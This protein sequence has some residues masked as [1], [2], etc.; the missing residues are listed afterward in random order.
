MHR[1]HKNNNE[2]TSLSQIIPNKLAKA[3]YEHKQRKGFL[4]DSRRRYLT[5]YTIRI[6]FNYLYNSNHTTMLH[7]VFNN[8]YTFFVRLPKG[9]RKA[10]DWITELRC[11]SYYL[12]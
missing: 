11:S 4:D 2:K 5:N 12:K 9:I 10:T 1:I 3:H 8:P 6:I 7:T